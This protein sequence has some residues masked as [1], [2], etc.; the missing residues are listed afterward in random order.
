MTT[1]ADSNQT[2]EAIARYRFTMMRRMS[3]ILDDGDGRAP[4]VP[5]PVE[6]S[7]PGLLVSSIEELKVAEEE[8]RS[9]NA[10]LIA[11]RAR[12]DERTR[13]YRELF[14]QS[15]A[16][17]LITDLFGTIFEANFAAGELF[18]RSPDFLVRKPIAAMVPTE[19]RD[20][21]RRQ[22]GNLSPA[23]GPR[24]WHFTISRVGDVPVDVCATVQLVTGLGPT[25]SG[26]LCWLF[27]SNGASP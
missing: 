14:L 17:T 7:L 25:A 3:Q 26:V 21:F 11:Q 13:H 24:N 6:P 5:G 22:F 4:Q 1:G 12:I 2:L 27:V 8:L 9:Q 19:N 20:A 10:T 18:R 23:S 15:P 16:P